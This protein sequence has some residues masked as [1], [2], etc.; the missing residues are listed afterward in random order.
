M[1][2]RGACVLFFTLV[3]SPALFAQIFVSELGDGGWRADDSR[4]TQG[5]DLVGAEFTHHGKPGQTATIADDVALANRMRF[6]RDPDSP[7]GMGSLAFVLDAAP[8]KSSKSTLSLVNETGFGAGSLLAAPDFSATYQWTQSTAAGSSRLAFRF[9]LQTSAFGASQTDFTATRTGEDVWDVILV[10]VPPAGQIG[11]WNK[12]VITPDTTGWR[13]YFQAGNTFWQTNYGLTSSN[14]ALGTPQ[15]LSYWAAFDYDQNTAG[16][17]SFLDDAAITSIQFGLG[18]SSAPTGESY[19]ASFE[20]S[21][22]SDSY[23]FAAIPEFSHLPILFG[24]G[25]LLAAFGRRALRRR[26]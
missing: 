15:S 2:L 17:Q 21:L 6:D 13:V 26:R 24:A 22:L 16:T 1:C 11:V 12:T 23:T 7:N 20:T 4:N 19:L 18:S 3:S 9:G 5:V 8:G 14:G 10:Y 25:A